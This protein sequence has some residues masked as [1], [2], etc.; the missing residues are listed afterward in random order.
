[1]AKTE[2][3]TFQNVAYRL[4]VYETGASD[5]ANKYFSPTMHNS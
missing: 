3:I 5:D 2:E 1:M 4:T